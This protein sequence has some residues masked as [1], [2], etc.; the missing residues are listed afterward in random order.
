MKM[1]L[2]LATMFL[3][4]LPLISISQESAPVYW[5]SF[6]KLNVNQSDHIR[7][8][9]EP[10]SGLPDT[11]YGTYTALK[12]GVHGNSLL[13]D[14]YSSYLS[15]S[16]IPVPEGNFSVEVWIAPGAYPTNFCPVAEQRSADARGF[17]LG[18]DSEGKAG[19]SVATQTGWIELR[20]SQK[21]PLY[22]WTHL[23]GVY[24]GGKIALLIN[25]EKSAEKQTAGRFLPA[26]NAT[27][28]CG[29]SSQRSL[30]TGVLNPGGS[31]PVNQFFDG[32]VDDLKIWDKALSEKE[33]STIKKEAG[34][35]SKPALEKRSLP[36]LLPADRFRVCYANL[37]YYESWDNFWRISGDPDVVV[38]FEKNG[39]FVFWRGTSY[40]PH[41]VTENGIW[42]NNEFNETWSSKGCHEPMSD[43]R[44]EHSQVK[45]VESTPARCVVHWRYALVDNWYNQ[46]NIDQVT[47]WGDWTDELYTIYPDGTAVRSQ[48]LHSSKPSSE[49]EWHEGIIVMGPGQRPEDVLNPEALIMSNMKGEEHRYSWDPAAADVKK[50]GVTY[51]NQ[52][53]DSWLTEPEG[54]NIQLVNTR[55]ALKP[56]TVINP[57]DD[58]KWDF[59]ND[60]SRRHVSMFPWWNHWPTA[61]K[62][63]D[64]RYAMD[65]D[66]ASHSSL[67]HARNWKA[68]KR[69]EFSET[70]LMLVGLTDGKA[71]DLAYLTRSWS[72]APEMS[73]EAESVRKIGYEP[74]EKAYQLECVKPGI[75]SEFEIKLNCSPEFPSVHPAFVIRNWGHHDIMV[76]VNG[77]KMTENVHYRCGFAD[78]ID[79]A[80]LILWFD[81]TFKEE[82]RIG[83]L[84]K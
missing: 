42:Y 41:W 24:N 61:F 80:N 84:R 77:R 27:F 25:G 54:A 30:P 6:D 26:K 43:K 51:L 12:E 17:S 82:T 22:K 45:I 49:F 35:L 50:A 69:T 55:S 48:T 23:C 63:S 32:L 20:R 38:S 31:E 73:V 62:P 70:R 67:T 76:E 47:G 83:V 72:Y 21:I 16:G 19:F 74:S 14:G 66:R 59:Y 4:A 44:C 34:E 2:M 8:T 56:F 60:L 46:S 29:M 78:T 58:P 39:H 3:S 9:N 1:I 13:L 10:I 28:C 15:A 18:I 71:C 68:Y 75:C 81:Q 52:K 79:G 11:L 40:I 64:G 65:S 57:D 5:L 33:F 7:T 36:E 37:K 53:S